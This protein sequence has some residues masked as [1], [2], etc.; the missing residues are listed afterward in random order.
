[1]PKTEESLTPAINAEAVVD[2]QVDFK[3]AELSLENLD[4]LQEAATK[5]AEKLDNLVVT[6]DTATAA[7]KSSSELNA[8][9]KNLD[10]KRKDIK[11]IYNQ[12]LSKFEAQVKSVIA[13]LKVTKENINAGL[14]NLLVQRKQELKDMIQPLIADAA[15]RNDV[16]PEDIKFDDK[17][18][19]LNYSEIQ[20]MRDIDDAAK[21]AAQ[22]KKYREAQTDKVSAKAAELHLE[23]SGW[24]KSLELNGYDTDNTLSSMAAEAKAKAGQ[25]RK[26][27]TDTGEIVQKTITVRLTASPEELEGVLMIIANNGIKYEEV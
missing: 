12:P 17:W 27:D 2:A 8:I 1:M 10:Q 26:V 19:N 14:K 21:M 6:E 15:K 16:Q 11:A 9:I 25:K 22:G 7:R 5:Y 4:D 3:P 23:A 18:L 24:L 13:P 20:R